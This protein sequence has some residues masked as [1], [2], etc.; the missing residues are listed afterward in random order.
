M[1]FNWIIV[2]L[3]SVIILSC[4]NEKNDNLSRAEKSQTNKDNSHENSLILPVLHPPNTH[5][6]LDITTPRQGQCNTFRV[7]YSY[8]S[9]GLYI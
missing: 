9:N 5:G 1:N 3:I 7:H 4:S 8:C 6:N 2:G